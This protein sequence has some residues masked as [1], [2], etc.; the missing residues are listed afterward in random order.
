MFFN[1]IR[2]GQILANRF[3][4]TIEVLVR[5]LIYAF[6]ITL[7]TIPVKFK[8]NVDSIEVRNTFHYYIAKI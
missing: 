8:M 5:A 3:R 7:I 4:E 6:V 2:G 1:F